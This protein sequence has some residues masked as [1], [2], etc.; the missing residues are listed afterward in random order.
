M[1]PVALQQAIFDRL[2]AFAALTALIDAVR[3]HVP[4]DAV[5]PYVV[6]G[7]DTGIP[8]DTHSSSGSDTTATIHTWSRERGKKETK[9][10]QR[11]IYLALHRFDLVVAGVD[12]VDCEWEFAESFIDEDGLTRHGVQRFRIMLDEG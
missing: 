10:I 12:T 8:L 9:E 6:I 4:Q 5:F 3:D 1:T 7:E 2:N 11:Q